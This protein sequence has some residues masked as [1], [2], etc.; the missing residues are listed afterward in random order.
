[1]AQQSRR[2]SA[3]VLW[4]LLF[5][6]ALA[7]LIVLDRLVVAGQLRHASF[8]AGL[9]SLLLS[10]GVLYV[11]G[12]ALF[13]LAG[14]L[15][16][17]RSGAVESGVLAGLLA[18]ILAG[19]T[20]LVFTML[21]VSAANRHLQ[22]AAAARGLLPAL[23]AAVGSAIFSAAVAFLAVSFVGAGVGALGG[24][25]GRGRGRRNQTFQG[26]NGMVPPAFGYPPFPPAP[27]P[28]SSYTPLITHQNDAQGTPP[29]SGYDPP[30]M[31]PGPYPGGDSPTIQTSW[32]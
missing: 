31:P 7:L 29:P 21:A 11:I 6:L 27:A 19:L 5:G 20:N 3:T 9:V 16:A 12:V 28:V 22:R 4:S 24:L 23:H 13:F 18:G 26:G 2:A 32:P 25:A 8:G 1:M 14:I 15:A 10:R 17:R 30:P